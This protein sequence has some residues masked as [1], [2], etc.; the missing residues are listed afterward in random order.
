VLREAVKIA[1]AKGGCDGISLRHV[2]PA[3]AG[4]TTP[5]SARVFAQRRRHLMF[6][7]NLGKTPMLKT[8]ALGIATAASL[9]LGTAALTFA[10]AN[11]AHCLEAPSAADCQA[12]RAEARAKG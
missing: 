8:I 9:S 5:L 7:L 4:E 2:H 12:T 3:T 10:S 6:H 11:Y 1:A